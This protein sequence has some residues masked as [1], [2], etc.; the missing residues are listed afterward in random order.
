MITLDFETEAI[1][2]NPITHPPKPVGLAVTYSDMLTKYITEESEMGETLDRAFSGSEDLCFHN[3][4]FDLSVAHKWFGLEFPEWHRIHDTVYLCYLMNPHADSLSLKPSAEHYLDLPPE[5]QDDLRDWILDNVKGANKKNW[6]AFICRAPVELVEPYA[7]GDTIRT[8]RLF[9]HLIEKVP[10]EPY[11]RERELMPILVNAT[12][13]GIRVDRHALHIAWLACKQS[14]ERCENFIR[15]KL[16]MPD[17][18]PHSGIELSKALDAAGKMDQWVLT[19]TG[20]KSTARK[21]LMAGINDQELLQLLMYTG[22]MQTLLGTFIEPWLEKSEA[23]GRLHPNWNQVR[24]TEG[25]RKGTRTGRM[26]SDDP[27]FQNVPTPFTFDIHQDLIDM[28]IM[29]SFILPEEGHVW[30]KRDWSGQEMRILAHFEDGALCA[31]YNDNPDLDPHTMVQEII[32]QK[33]GKLLDRKFVKETGFGMI[34]GMGA[35]GLATKIGGGFTIG[36]ARELQ[37]AYKLAMPGVS[38]VQAGTKQRGSNGQPIT[39][40]GGRKYYAEKPRI[41]GGAYRSFEYKLCNYLIQGSAADQAK[42]CL[43]DW[44]NGSTGGAVFM[45]AVHDEIN[46]SAPEDTW[47][48]HMKGLKCCMNQDYFDVPMRSSAFMGPTWGDIKEVEE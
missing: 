26:S 33:V 12:V 8:R 38:I 24:S 23:D 41:I 22:A 9:D 44:H 13:K 25:Q 45:A 21:N 37:D 10:Q 42:Q 43:I 2:G 14:Q 7:K 31:A 6:G 48:P 15:D 35:N 4:P 30:L 17:L 16:G 27:N 46:I 28:P 36:E 20:K 47:R 19:P 11:D 5:E 34:Y 40:W 39:T 18:N 3:A 32:H 1:V 29:R